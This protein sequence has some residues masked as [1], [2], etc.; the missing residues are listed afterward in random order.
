MAPAS[1]TPTIVLFRTRVIC[2][3]NLFLPILR[4]PGRTLK[5]RVAR[6]ARAWVHLYQGNCDEPL[7][8]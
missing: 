8:S 6:I 3:P 4:L 1:A 5:R 7:V 2:I